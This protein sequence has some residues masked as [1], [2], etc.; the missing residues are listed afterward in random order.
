MEYLRKLVKSKTFW[1]GMA[2]IVTGL[3]LYFTGEQSITE[4]L[5]GAG[6]IITIIFRLVTTESIGAK[7]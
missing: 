4:L 5:V 7:K 1:A 6:G 2:Q 3:G